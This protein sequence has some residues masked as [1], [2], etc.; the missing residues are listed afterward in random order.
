MSSTTVAR[1]PRD[2]VEGL[3][4]LA[5]S[6]IANALD[7]VGI[8]GIIA[9]LK[10]VAA[11]L[12]CVGPAVTVRQTT[13]PRG[14]IPAEDFRVGHMID[15]AAAGDVI[16]VDNGGHPVST[17][18][19]LASYAAMRKQVAGLVVDGGVRDVA[20]IADHGFPVFSRHTVPTPGRTRIRVEAIN[21]AISVAGVVVHP[22]DIIVA[23]A[24]GVVCIPTDHADEV[25]RLAQRNA[26]EDREAMDA[27]GQG[28]SFTEALRRFRRI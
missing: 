25:L 27:L 16:V 5:T 1:P 20:E 19:G 9:G 12:G 24:T 18:G 17:W 4:G 10:P 14:S 7:D 21:C 15:A 23:D 26:R 11:G 8:D 28:L 2:L 13:G 3:A 22:G 6:T